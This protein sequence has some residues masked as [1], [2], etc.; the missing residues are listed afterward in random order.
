VREFE[1]SPYLQQKSNL[2]SIT[3]M[4]VEGPFFL[5]NP[6][7]NSAKIIIKKYIKKKHPATDHSDSHGKLC[8]P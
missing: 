4:S 1:A 8:T 5:E 7:T 3:F 2:A 6:F